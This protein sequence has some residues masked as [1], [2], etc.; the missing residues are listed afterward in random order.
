MKRGEHT[1]ASGQPGS[2][3][4]D[5]A[6]RHSPERAVLATVVLVLLAF[7]ITFQFVDP[8]PPSVIRMSAGSPGGAYFAYAQRYRE[9]LAAEGIE[10]RIQESAGSVQ[11][12]ARLAAG[13]VGLAF[14]QGGVEADGTPH[15]D[16]GLRSLGSLYFEP[17]WVFHR[18]AD[19]PDRLTALAG[20]R[21]A[22]GA[23]GSGTR[24]LALDLL[25][26]A[27]VE[28]PAE[29]ALEL[30]GSDAIEALLAGDVDVVF[31]VAAADSEPVRR[32][33]HTPDVRLMS[34]ARAEAYARRLPY[35]TKVELPAGLVDMAADLPP[36][37]VTLL[38]A[39][40]NLVAGPDLHPAFVPLM[41]R[42][43]QR[44]HHDGGWFHGGGDFPRPDLLAFPLHEDAERSYQGGT[45]FLQRYLPFWAADLVDRL[46]ILL[47]PL[48]ALAIPLFRLLPPIYNWRM[49][50]RIYRW[51]RDLNRLRRHAI[52]EASR[53]VLEA[54]LAEA[55][56]M[57]RQ[58][59]EVSVP[60]AFAAQLY[61]L[62]QH[63]RLVVS[64]LTERLQS[65]TDAV[66]SNMSA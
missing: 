26:V 30:G 44:I 28:T 59:D 1:P 31:M 20:K 56:E 43:A 40:A 66:D 21:M 58:L 13:E 15:A 29:K 39:A 23:P 50:A 11:N 55:A 27:G 62:R 22:I 35:L 60:L 5:R 45:P 2:D 47:L 38:A 19:A 48:L 64:R 63:L 4:D 49:R 37:D 57:E 41:V 42:T 34:L 9:A 17:F 51:Y 25:R 53:D 65:A 12:I 8:A 3:A 18:L 14:V 7:A 24:A 16:D 52:G 36:H 32:L 6:E 54:A 10:L 46:K 33:L 61:D